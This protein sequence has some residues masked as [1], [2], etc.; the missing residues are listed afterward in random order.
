[1]DKNT[2]ETTGVMSALKG[3]GA[4]DKTKKGVHLLG[5]VKKLSAKRASQ[6]EEKGEVEDKKETKKEEA[7]EKD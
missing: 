1:M 6:K 5:I 3:R 2:K 4:L 7:G